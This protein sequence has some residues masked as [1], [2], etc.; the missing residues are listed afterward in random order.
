LGPHL[1]QYRLSRGY[2]RIK[3][4]LDPSSRLATVDKGRGLYGLRQ[5]V[6]K[7]REWGLLSPLPW[8]S[9]V[10]IQHNVALAETYLHTKW[11]PN[12]SNRLV[13]IH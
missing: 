1:T 8:R 12:P 4:H 2:L 3:W 6:R 13:T 11:H 5:S 10:P 7:L 9:W